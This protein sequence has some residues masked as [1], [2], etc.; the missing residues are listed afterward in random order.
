MKRKNLI[1]KLILLMFFLLLALISTYPAFIGHTFRLTWDGQIHLIRFESIADAIKNKELPPI[2]NFMGYG[3]V[4]EVFNGM[5]PWLSGLMFIIPRVLLNSPMHALFIGFYLLNILT[6]LN[7]YL[8]VRKLSKNYYIRLIGIVLYQLNAYHLTLMY[9]RNALGEALA[10]TFLPLVMLGCYL[11]WNN[12]KLGIL[13]LALGMGMVIN[14]HMISSILALLLIVV[15]ELYRII[16]RKISLKE[17][18]HIVSAGFLSIPLVAFTIINIGN[19]ALK[20]RIATTWRGI[21]AIDMWETLQAMLQNDITEKSTIFNI[22]IMC[23][24]L[25]SILLVIAV[26]S[27]NNGKWKGY[28]LGAGIVYI[29]TLNVIPLPTKLSQSPVGVI[30]FTGRLLSIVMLLLTIGCVLFLKVNFDK[31]NVKSSLFFLFM[32]MSVLAIGSVRTY[33][34]AVN[35]NLINNSNYIKKISTPY[36]GWDDYILIN[37]NKQPVLN[38]GIPKSNI[39][40]VSYDS[41]TLRMD[42]KANQVPFLLYKGIPYEVKV[43]GKNTKIK[44]GSILK[45]K[46][47]RGDMIQISSKATWWNYL[48]FGISVLT[49]LLIVLGIV[50]TEFVNSGKE[51][52]NET[53]NSNDDI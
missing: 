28:I 10:Y 52:K 44:V 7:T 22:G 40:K 23:F 25:L 31:I 1:Q 49:L 17:I 18:Y 20:N 53:I 14:S 46:V 8:L 11:I 19:I 3:N 42:K 36:S 27:K 24:I 34:N 41:I 6:I 38:R 21:G 9:S 26:T 2:V 37:K 16:S 39:V 51:Y 29:L 45:L 12:E 30:Q 33:H 43:N 5:Y 50:A 32:M 35:D 4:G 47:K 13:Y 15:A 48:T